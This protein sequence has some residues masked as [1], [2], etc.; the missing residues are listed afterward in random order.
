MFSVVYLTNKE[1]NLLHNVLSFSLIL[2]S[3]PIGAIQLTY[4]ITVKHIESVHDHLLETEYVK[5]NIVFISLVYC[6]TYYT[7]I[8]RAVY[9]VHM[10]KDTRIH[11]TRSWLTLVV[12]GQSTTYTAWISR[13]TFKCLPFKIFI[14]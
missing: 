9:L 7:C 1:V 12:R 4:C 10:Y 6:F 3:N 2:F 5:V 8:I 11:Q 13:T 14:Y